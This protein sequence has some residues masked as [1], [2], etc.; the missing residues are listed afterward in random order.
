MEL[1]LQSFITPS[2]R[3]AQ[4]KLKD[5]FTLTFIVNITIPA[6]YKQIYFVDSDSQQVLVT[7]RPVFSSE[8]TPRDD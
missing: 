8:M 3:G 5:N 2:W 7:D 4:L 6:Y 1:Y